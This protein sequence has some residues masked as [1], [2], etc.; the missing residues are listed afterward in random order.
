MADGLDDERV[1]FQFI[2]KVHNC[3]DLLDVSSAG[4]NDTNKKQKKLLEELVVRYTDQI[5]I[6]IRF[7]PNLYNISAFSVSSLAIKMQQDQDT[8]GNSS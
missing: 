6:A 3:P 8:S 4:Y 5:S 7:R 1:T 2:D